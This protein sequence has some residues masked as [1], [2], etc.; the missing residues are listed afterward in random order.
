VLSGFIGNQ[1]LELEG[2]KEDN[3]EYRIH[4]NAYS[5]K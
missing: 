2:E 4:E 5:G 3:F 1:I